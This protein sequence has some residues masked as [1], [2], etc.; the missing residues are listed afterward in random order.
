[1]ELIRCCLWWKF[2][3]KSFLSGLLL[4]TATI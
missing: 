2:W 3:S 1:V 4:K